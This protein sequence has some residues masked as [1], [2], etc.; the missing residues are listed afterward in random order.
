MLTRRSRL[1]LG[2]ASV[3]LLT[4]TVLGL[5][6]RLAARRRRIMFKKPED[7]GKLVDGEMN[8]PVFDVVI[9]GGGMHVVSL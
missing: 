3:L 7:I 1:L 9:V 6:K 8:E 4:Y 5:L 2:S